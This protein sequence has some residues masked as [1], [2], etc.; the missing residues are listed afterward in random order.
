[1]KTTSATCTPVPSNRTKQTATAV[2]LGSG[3]V[4]VKSIVLQVGRSSMTFPPGSK[5]TVEKILPNPAL[6]SAHLYQSKVVN[7]DNASIGVGNIPRDY[8]SPLAASS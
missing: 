4:L 2:E 1:M 7:P 6:K 3:F 8:F 5:G